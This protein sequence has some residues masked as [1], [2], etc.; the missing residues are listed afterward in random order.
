MYFLLKSS[1]SCFGRQNKVMEVMEGL[2]Y[3]RSEERPSELE[4]LCLGK[5]GHS[6]VCVDIRWEGIKK[7]QPGSSQWCT[8]Q[9]MR[10]GT[11]I[12]I[13]EILLNH[14]RI[15]LCVCEWSTTRTGLLEKLWFFGDAQKQVG[16]GPEQLGFGNLL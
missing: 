11:Q 2:E 3:L 5:R 9:D 15:F 4:L 6:G 13:Q 12:E 14:R 16:H 10:R 8:K 1:L 7:I